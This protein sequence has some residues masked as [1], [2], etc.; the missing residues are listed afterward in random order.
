[1]VAI[2]TGAGGATAGAVIEHFTKEGWSLALVDR[3]SRCSKLRE[4]FPKASVYGA[5]LTESEQV[6]Q[7]TADALS[8]YGKIDALLCTAGGFAM[9]RAVDA[10]MKDVERQLKLNFRTLFE[11]TSA[12]LPNMLDR[13]AGFI[14]GIAA[15]AAI[16]GGERMSAYG[17]SKAALVGYL[18]SVRAE[19][20]QL[21]IGVSI[22]YPIGTIDTPANRIAMPNA[23]YENWISGRQVAE[24][25]HFL[26]TRNRRGRVREMSLHV[27]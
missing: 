16:Q 6:R 4:Q 1:M 27:G 8:T 26:A 2:V 11:I 7:A 22:L 3:P 9:Q 17:A 10:N 21:G 12:V 15:S 19:V 20:E 23:S 13:G 25:I 18:R 5:D 24:A 14:L